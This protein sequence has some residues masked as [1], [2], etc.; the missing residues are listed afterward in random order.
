[1]SVSAMRN[2][3]YSAKH[4]LNQSQGSN[5]GTSRILIALWDS[6]GLLP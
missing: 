3:G 4:K 1:M 6:F 2:L 5:P